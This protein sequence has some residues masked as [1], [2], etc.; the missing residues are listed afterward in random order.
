MCKPCER[1]YGYDDSPYD[2]DTYN[3][4]KCNHEFKNKYWRSQF[5]CLDCE[6]P[7]FKNKAVCGD[8]NKTFRS[9]NEDDRCRD[10]QGDS[11]SIYVCADCESPKLAPGSNRCYTCIDG[12]NSI[13]S[14]AYQPLPVSPILSEEE[15]LEE[16]L[17][18]I[19]EKVERW[20]SGMTPAQ[21]DDWRR[22]WMVKELRLRKLRCRGCRDEL[23]NQ[24]GHTEPGGC[25]HDDREDPWEDYD[26]DDLRKMDLYSRRMHC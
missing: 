13:R 1:Y 11:E 14:D 16:E 19:K 10:C 23:L 2:G 18:N 26:A 22:M 6:A 24:Q 7:T 12:A 3:C 8:C 15:Q 21:V 17:A 20:S 5:L 4:T 9:V 25:M